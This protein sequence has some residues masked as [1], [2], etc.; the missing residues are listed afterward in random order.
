MTRPQPRTLAVFCDG[1]NAKGLDAKG[2]AHGRVELGKLLGFTHDGRPEQWTAEARPPHI[3]HES[4]DLSAQLDQATMD[5]LGPKGRTVREQAE[6]LSGL[7]SWFQITCP[8]C[9]CNYRSGDALST[10]FDTASAQLAA[11]VA[12]QKQR[13]RGAALEPIPAANQ[14]GHARL[15]KFRDIRDTGAPEIRLALLSAILGLLPKR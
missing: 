3:T 7:S 15:T 2:R 1:L 9:P 14:Y 6:M 5:M 10:G 8:T 11:V 12:R 13:D 4:A